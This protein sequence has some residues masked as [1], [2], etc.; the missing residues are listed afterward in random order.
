MTRSAPDQHPPTPMASLPTGQLP[1]MVAQPVAPALHSSAGL[2][3]LSLLGRIA[4]ATPQFQHL[5]KDTENTFLK[6]SYLKLPSLLDAIRE[7]LLEYGVKVYS[8]GCFADG[9]WLVR[10]TLS[11]LDGGEE[12]S[13]DFPIVGEGLTMQK[14]AGCFTLGTRYNLFALLN[15]C[16]DSGDD[17][18]N[19]GNSS[20]FASGHS[21]PGLGAPQPQPPQQFAQSLHPQQYAQPYPQQFAQA[22]QPGAIAYPVNPLPV[23]S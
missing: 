22:A 5:T 18:G 16:P 20:A 8:Q 7:P 1:P 13:S 15:I 6:S 11:T 21:L 3:N 14:V 9:Q 2:D 10:T 4:A 12:L 17:D 23:L 19:V